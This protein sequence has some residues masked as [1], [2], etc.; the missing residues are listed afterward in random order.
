PDQGG[1]ALGALERRALVPP[2]RPQ[3]LGLGQPR[4]FGQAARNGGLQHDASPRLIALARGSCGAR[5]PRASPRA[6][7]HFSS[8]DI[9]AA[10]IALWFCK[11]LGLL[12]SRTAPCRV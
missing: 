11:R 5:R 7:R 6:C 12:L 8:E 4:R 3:L 9:T 2:R 10:F 1:V